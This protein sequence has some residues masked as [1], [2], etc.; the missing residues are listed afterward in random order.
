[1][2]KPDAY[3][4]TTS[5]AISLV[6]LVFSLYNQFNSLAVNSRFEFE[7]IYK[8]IWQDR[9]RII[10]KK[11]IKTDKEQVSILKGF[12]KSETFMQKSFTDKLR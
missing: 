9:I 3:I 5:M 12:F 2:I 11:M 10:A 6:Y 7:R 1:M 8:E 4:V